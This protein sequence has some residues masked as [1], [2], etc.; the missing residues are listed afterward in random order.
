MSIEQSIT[1]KLTS[2]LAPALLE[3][4]N[5]S[6]R[7][8]GHAGSPGTGE[9]HFHIKIVSDSFSGKA[10]LERHRQV[11]DIL[12][13]ELSGPVHALSIAALTPEEHANQSG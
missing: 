3:V 12:Q 2:A 4:N 10:R 11:N 9:S 7:H 1:E 6:D 8:Q 5:E 13:D